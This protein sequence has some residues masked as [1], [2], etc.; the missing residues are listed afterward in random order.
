MCDRFV[1]GTREWVF[2]QVYEWFN[3]GKSE[4]VNRAFII[5]GEAGM[6]KSVIAA[7]V[8]KRL[9]EQ[10]AGCHFISYKND[11][12]NNPKILLQ[13]LALKIS[14]V[15]DEYKNALVDHLS[16]E[17]GGKNINEMNIESL[18]S[19]L[20]KGLFANVKNPGKNI[21]FVIDGVDESCDSKERSELVD[22]IADH[23]H[24]LP[25]FIRF[26]IT[27]RPQKNIVDKFKCLHPLYLIKDDENNKNDLKI[28]FE[29]KL[30]SQIASR[31]S[32]IAQLTSRSDGLMLYAFYIFDCYKKERNHENFPA[33]L[34]GVFKSY[35]ER[36][37]K[38]CTTVLNI[39]ENAFLS[40]L[41]AMVDAKEP[42]SLDFVVS[43]LGVKRETASEKRHAAKVMNCISLLF[44]ITDNHVSFFH[45]SVKDWVVNGEYHHFQIVEKRGHDVL[46]QLCA[47]CFEN[48]MSGSTDL[49]PSK[50]TDSS[51]HALRNGFFHMIE[52]D[53]NSYLNSYLRN[54][55]IICRCVSSQDSQ[56][57]FAK[58]IAGMLRIQ[59]ENQVA[60][61]LQEVIDIMEAVRA[62]KFETYACYDLLHELM[63][64]EIGT[65]TVSSEALKLLS[66]F[67]PKIPSFENVDD[68]IHQECPT[69]MLSGGEKVVRSADVHTN[70]NYV[71]LCFESGV[72]KLITPEPLE[73]IW[74]KSFARKEISCSCIAFHPIQD[75]ILPGRLDQV[76]VLADGSLQ[77]GPF[78]FEANFSLPLF[79]TCCCFSPD[80]KIMITGYSG[81]T[82]LHVWNLV[83]SLYINRIELIRSARSLSFS[84]NGNYL[85]VLSGSCHN[86]S[87][88]VTVFDVQ[89]NYKPY[90]SIVLERGQQELFE[91]CG[92]NDFASLKGYKSDSWIVSFA[93]HLYSFDIDGLGL[94]FFSPN[95]HPIFPANTKLRES[96]ET[97]ITSQIMP[98]SLYLDFLR[99]LSINS[100]D[101]QE[102][103]KFVHE[104][105]EVTL[106]PNELELH[107][108]SIV[109]GNI[110]F[111]GQFFYQHFQ[112]SRK[113]SKRNA[114]DSTSLVS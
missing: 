85:A 58:N 112:S 104:K 50:L 78:S 98:Q 18:F 96:L 114:S 7:V 56:H 8:C 36:L 39:S 111:D 20:L 91:L 26:L 48:L 54:L 65:G 82:Y 55:E 83:S 59:P 32:L 10:L 28:F 93:H 81:D 99:F 72:V 75:K 33:D 19:L 69:L 15:L 73:V 42:L 62:D 1:Q 113:L 66:R 94:T 45:K 61:V 44:T 6:G 106:Y 80:E 95:V 77:P 11:R 97:T 12:Y 49:D 40:L 92:D 103:C 89:N 53:V 76:L 16:R 2:N 87:A 17:L 34:N 105:L 79:F 100:P 43:I 84:S 24:K 101:L 46:A 108:T 88:S 4:S 110:S 25:H 21:L 37:E 109:P 22:L 30:S 102:G 107:S 52:Y 29:T 51:R 3:Y 47:N 57:L 41:S 23:L 90:E 13:S 86:T 64:C 35:F 71:V 5:T 14:N 74:T 68:N 67:Y 9:H 38:E 27:T 60:V 70:L 31:Q 63:L